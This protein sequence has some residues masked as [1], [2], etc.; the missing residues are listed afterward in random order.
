MMSSSPNTR[1]TS[2]TTPTFASETTIISSP[3]S[4]T[5]TLYEDL[6]PNTLTICGRSPDFIVNSFN[7][8]TAAITSAHPGN[9]IVLQDGVYVFPGSLPWDISGGI[10][11][12][13]ICG[14]SRYATI[15][16][17]EETVASSGV[18]V[19]V[20]A[21]GVRIL[22]M[23]TKTGFLFQNAADDSI[24]LRNV[25]LQDV[26]VE[27]SYFG[28]AIRGE[29]YN[30][31]N[32]EFKHVFGNFNS[33]IS[34]YGCLGTCNISN[35]RFLEMVDSSSSIFVMVGQDS[36]TD[37]VNGTV[38]VRNNTQMQLKSP[39]YFLILL[40]MLPIVALD[41]QNNTFHC[42]RSFI[43]VNPQQSNE[44]DGIS[45]ITMA[46]NTIYGYD[47]QGL[48]LISSGSQNKI[49]P[50]RSSPLPINIPQENLLLDDTGNVVIEPTLTNGVIECVGSY[51]CI[52]TVENGTDVSIE[53]GTST[54]TAPTNISTNS[55]D[56]T[57]SVES[58]EHHAS[59]YPESSLGLA[60]VVALVPQFL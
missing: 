7:E 32:C 21:D 35:N 28:A 31:T 51:D 2:S 19:Q 12:L 5:P 37:Y 1:F 15:I 52:S 20:S 9:L 46:S 26:S 54:T 41:V 58:T 43:L 30:V 11:N 29:S 53:S 57:R 18:A 4:S 38:V 17:P 40:N 8:L 14:S 6:S 13:T 22:R 34:L 10:E 48:V 23:S 59:F 33:G 60:L 44:G 55:N 27:Y 49:A 42:G 16:Q 50:F 25:L 45:S 36:P 3:R 39:V 24:Y 56:Q 47:Y